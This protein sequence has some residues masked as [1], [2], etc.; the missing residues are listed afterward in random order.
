MIND[1]C[2]KCDGEGGFESETCNQCGGQGHMQQGP[3]AFMCNNCS[4]SGKLYKNVCYSCQGKGLIKKQKSLN[5]K[6]PKGLSEGQMI[7]IVG[8]GDRIKDGITGDVYFV[9]RVKKHDIYQVEGINLKR[10]IDVPFLD[11]ILGTEKEF[12]T[13]DGNVKIKI[14]K[15]SE[16]NKTFRLKGK[17]FT[18][19]QTNLIGDMY[20]TINPILPKDLNSIEEN[21]LKQ[22]K[23]MPNFK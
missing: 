8:V 19:S 20:V 12:E 7:P 16:M 21:K 18:D 9:V 17:G 6:I 4:G 22:L 2:V 5:I 1:N 10:K 14:P 13:I 23:N 3:F 11:I 15:L